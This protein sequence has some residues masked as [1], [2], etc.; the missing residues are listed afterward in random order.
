MRG[1]HEL[2]LGTCTYSLAWHG[3]THVVGFGFQALCM[4]M[5]QAMLKGSAAAHNALGVLFHEGRDVPQDAA[6]AREHFEAGAALGDVDAMFNLGMTLLTENEGANNG[7]NPELELALEHLLDANENQHWQAPYQ[8]II[9]QLCRTEI[10]E[11]LF[12]PLLQA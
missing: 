3:R 7:S 5:P 12:W 11:P 4:C 1:Q 8:V 2:S 10:L 6:A 9:Q